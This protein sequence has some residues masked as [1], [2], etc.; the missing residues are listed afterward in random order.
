M[1]ARARCRYPGRSWPRCWPRGTSVYCQLAPPVVEKVKPL[2]VCSLMHEMPVCCEMLQRNPAAARIL[3]NG[4]V[5]GVPDGC[6]NC[7]AGSEANCGS[8]CVPTTIELGAALCPSASVTVSGAPVTPIRPVPELDWQPAQ[9]RGDDHAA[10]A[11]ARA[12][13]VVARADVVGPGVEIERVDQLVIAG[14]A[15]RRCGSDRWSGLLAGLLG[16]DDRVGTAGQGHH[17]G[18]QDEQWPGSS[19]ETSE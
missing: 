6:L 4:N 9:V 15:S 2:P 7:S 3:L 10:P 14:G 11:A 12:G 18:A 1:W 19:H 17:R 8:S 5:F 13:E 16:G